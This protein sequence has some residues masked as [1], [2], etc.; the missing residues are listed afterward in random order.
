MKFDQDTSVPMGVKGLESQV[1]NLGQW[2]KS[3]QT[4]YKREGRNH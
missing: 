1:V 3:P 4:I 2:K